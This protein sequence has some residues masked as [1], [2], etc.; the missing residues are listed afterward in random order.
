MNHDLL[1]HIDSDDPAVLNLALNNAANYFR[2]LPGETF[3]MV[4]VANGPAVKLFT[5]ANAGQAARGAELAAL[6]LDIR[7][8]RNALNS[9]G[10]ADADLWDCC[11]VVPAGVVEIVRLQREGAAYIKP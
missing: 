8:C 11:S 10:I 6:G 1:L 7:L 2:A 4:M 9:A 3:R 5:R